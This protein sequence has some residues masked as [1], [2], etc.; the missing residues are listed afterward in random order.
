MRVAQVNAVNTFSS[1]GRNTAELHAYLR[2][3][4]HE[5]AVFCTNENNPD[6]GVYSIGSQA[7]R[8]VHALLSRL[9]G[10]Q[11]W[12]SRRA[13]KKLIRELSR[14][15]PDV[16]LL[17]NLHGNYVNLPLLL[18]YLAKNNIPTVDV[19]HDCWTFTGHCCH[20]TAIG[21]DRWLSGCGRC[22]ALGR[23]NVSL[24]F[25]RS[26][27]NFKAKQRLWHSIPRLGVVGVSDWIASQARRSPVF[28]ESA[29]VVSIYN[30]VDLDTFK[31]SD[32]EAVS[33]LRASLGLRSDAPVAVSVSQLWSDAKGLGQI[34]R[35]A[36]LC[37]EVEFVLVGHFDADTEL[38]ANVHT[39][40]VV[41]SAVRLADYYSLADV[42]LNLS[43]QETFGKVSAEALA[44]GTPIVTNRLTANPELP[45][46]CGIVVSDPDSDS[47]I[48]AAL[49]AII[50]APM[51]YCSD[52]CRARAVALFSPATNINSYLNLFKQLI[53]K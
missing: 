51:D 10:R 43:R 16:V 5:S 45:G 30:W 48:A 53:E 8:K 2:S 35:M 18:G 20:Y 28:P 41:S 17:G 19:L 21:C 46:E 50:S 33:A 47:E 39:S 22:P 23:D 15:R 1:T 36:R 9:W 49:R 4:G 6:Q 26:E 29:S 24:L 52:K 42:Y 44:C 34:V 40:G 13:T 31:P 38:P 12:F 32:R 14:F 37:P 3:H 7:D 11:G 27:A 25:D